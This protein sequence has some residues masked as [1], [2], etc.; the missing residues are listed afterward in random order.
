MTSGCLQQMDKIAL[1]CSRPRNFESIGSGW[2]KQ[3]ETI[4]VDHH[5]PLFL[6]EIADA[7]LPA[8]NV[9]TSIGIA[10][11]WLDNHALAN[12]PCLFFHV[13]PSAFP[14]SNHVLAKTPSEALFL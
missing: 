3:R 10:Y 11:A 6:K 7:P 2:K 1:F 5:G 8:T 13:F 14:G 12:G 4:P 9:A